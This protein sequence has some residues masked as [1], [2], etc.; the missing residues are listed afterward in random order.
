MRS[1]YQR[2]LTK[3][4]DNDVNDLMSVKHK[5]VR[6]LS[7]YLGV[8]RSITSAQYSIESWNFS[9]YI[10]DVVEEGA[11]ECEYIIAK[12]YNPTYYGRPSPRLSMTTSR[13]IVWS[14]SGSKGFL[15]NGTN[16]KSSKKSKVSTNVALGVGLAS[17]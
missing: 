11:V 7:V 10:C 15:S 6:K 12:V 3:I 14:A 13:V 17:S 2:V 1:E 9:R 5:R 8:C 4:V 16:A